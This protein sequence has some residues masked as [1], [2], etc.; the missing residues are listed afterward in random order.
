MVCRTVLRL[1]KDHGA[2]AFKHVVGHFH[3]RQAELF[4]DLAS[5]FGAKVVIG[6]QAV[7]EK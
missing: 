5:H 1:V 2:L 7:H 6:G 4:V 3:L